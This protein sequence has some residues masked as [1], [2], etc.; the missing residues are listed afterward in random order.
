MKKFKLEIH[1]STAP[2]TLLLPGAEP[3][4]LNAATLV[5]MK[6]KAMGSPHFSH[7]KGVQRK[8]VKGR[9]QDD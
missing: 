4:S 5:E 7:M 8:E 9:R 6:A 3:F 1:P 2:K